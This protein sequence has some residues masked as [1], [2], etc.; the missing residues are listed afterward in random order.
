MLLSCY[1][2]CT[3]TQTSGRGLKRI[4]QILII[5]TFLALCS[6]Y[7]SPVPDG[8]TKN[9]HADENTG[10]VRITSRSPASAECS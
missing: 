8:A 5:L 10:G 4:N 3:L 9:P 6:L 1:P 7:L 2:A